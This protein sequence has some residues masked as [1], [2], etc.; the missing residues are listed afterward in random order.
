[1]DFDRPRVGN[2][3]ARL[4]LVWIVISAAISG[5]AG[6]GWLAGRIADTHWPDRD[7]RE[8]GIKAFGCLFLGACA[9]LVLAYFLVPLS[10][11][12]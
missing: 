10:W 9:I 11:L 12:R 1:M 3:L 5:L 4:V 2:A 7:R 8:D 6:V